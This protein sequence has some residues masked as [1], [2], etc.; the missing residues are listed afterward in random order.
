MKKT[1]F[2]FGE[3]LWDILPDRTV[4][5]GAPFNFA[6]R[7]NSL[8]DTG[9]MISRVGTDQLGQKALEKIKS[10]GLSTDFVQ[11]D[12]DL[13]TGT[14]KINFDAEK[15]ADI[16]IVPN[17]AYDQ[18][19]FNDGLADA[20]SQADCLCFGTLV[21]RAE[22]T[23][24]TVEQMLEKAGQSLKL[25]DI[26]L[27][28]SCYSPQTV[29]FSLQNADV[30]KLNDDEVASV[31]EML[32][33]QVKN[34]PAFCEQMCDKWSLKHIVVTFGAN[35]AFA[36]SHTGQ[37]VYVPG[38]KV[39]LAD[40]LGSGDAFSAGFIHKLLRDR[41]LEQA[42][43]YGNIMGALVATQPGATG[44]LTLEQIDKFDADDFEL[45]IH[46]QFEKFLSQLK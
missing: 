13:P 43:S 15:N 42:C 19:E 5:G 11:L 41:P 27:R 14:V 17:V 45:N 44:T 7:L 24:K 31:A 23:R 10:L 6:Y 25:L 20:V 33:M 34:I 38:Y 35:G 22:K 30:L 39:P 40:S 12:S 32:G 18:I 21:Q 46:P 9:L 16:F 3:V 26:N 37:K 1:V 36:F 28:K 29:S 2:A 8:G 4:L